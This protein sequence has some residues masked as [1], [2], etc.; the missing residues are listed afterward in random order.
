MTT[1]PKEAMPEFDGRMAL[2]TKLPRVELM[3]AKYRRLTEVDSRLLEVFHQLV[4][5]KAKWPLYLYGNAGGGKTCAALA[6]SD[7]VRWPSYDTVEGLATALV[8][9]DEV[10]SYR[11][12]DRFCEH[13]PTWDRLDSIR[14]GE[15]GWKP[16]LAILDELGTRQKTTDLHYQ[17]LKTFC[18]DRENC[19]FRVAVYISNLEPEAIARVYDDRVASRVLC[20][21]WFKLG[22]QDRRMI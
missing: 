4:S 15:G 10:G 3:P 9:G 12:L 13:W 21:T 6:L 14:K 5:G 17:A 20:G 18:D 2:G 19:F 11:S 16:G 1:V 8:N 22:G 7:V